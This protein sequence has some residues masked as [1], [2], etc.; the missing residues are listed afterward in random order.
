MTT[1]TKIK[2]LD[3]NIRILISKR[4]SPEAQS[5]AFA[6]FAE[7]KIEDAEAKDT[8][9]LGYK[10]P[11]RTYVDG[12]ETDDLTS[13]KPDGT[14]VVVF[15]IVGD[16]LQ[17]IYQMLV[18]RAPVLTGRFE[19]SIK[20]YADGAEVDPT[21]QIPPAGQYTFLSNVAYARKIEGGEGNNGR[22]PESSQAPDGVFQ[23]TAILAQQ[24]F[25]NTAKISFSFI[26]PADGGIV[27][28][29]QTPGAQ[30]HAN[31]RGGN[32]LLHQDWLTRV[33][34]IVVTTR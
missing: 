18:E 11:H 31:R 26:S 28:W 25:G 14:I 19:K 23:A 7:Q 3:E 2:S 13:V 24:K 9:A 15:D 1:T 22:R 20:L 27:D 30:V 10:P 16:V 5:A 32:K 21:G 33:P 4:L 12:S 34:A 8:A 17:T 6:A 29:A